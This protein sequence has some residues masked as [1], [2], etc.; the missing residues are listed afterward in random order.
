M[1]KIG[2][3]H[4]KCGQRIIRYAPRFGIKRSEPSKWKWI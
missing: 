1:L 3:E 2:D 4:K